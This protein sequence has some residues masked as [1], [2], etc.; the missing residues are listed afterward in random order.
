MRLI[1]RFVLFSF[2]VTVM[3]QAACGG[4]RPAASQ[5]VEPCSAAARLK[6]ELATV[7]VERFT[8]PDYKPGL[9]RHIVTGLGQERSLCIHRVIAI[10]LVCFDALLG[11]MCP[12]TTLENWLRAGRA[13][14]LP[15]R[16]HRLLGTSANLL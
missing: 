6:Q 9:V 3:S 2:L 16:F 1:R 15:R 4:P 12:L 5:N 10:G 14:V 13:G 7:G 11:L 8:P